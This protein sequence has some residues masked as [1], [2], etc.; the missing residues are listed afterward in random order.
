[1]G[2]PDSKIRGSNFCN[3]KVGNPVGMENLIKKNNPREG[4]FFSHALNPTVHTPD[5]GG[6]TG[7]YKLTSRDDGDVYQWIE[8]PL[9]SVFKT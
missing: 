3:K 2:C 6:E 8:S 4:A 7:G 9:S 5:F 1:M